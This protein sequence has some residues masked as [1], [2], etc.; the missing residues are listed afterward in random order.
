MA[1]RTVVPRSSGR[2]KIIY[3]DYK[4]HLTTATPIKSLSKRLQNQSGRNNRGIITTRHR[5]GKNQRKY[6]EI[7]FKRN[8]FDIPGIVKTVEYDPNRSCFISL[9][10]YANGKK[11]YIISPKDIKV[12]DKIVNSPICEIKN[13]NCIA[14]GNV[15]D[16]A[17]VHNVEIV[18]GA[19]GKLARSAGSFVQVMGKDETGKYSIIKLSSSETRKIPVNSMCTIGIVSNEDHNIINLGKA[20][21]S[22]KLGWKPTVR[23]SAMNPCDHPHG[24]GEGRQGAGMDAPRTPWGKR[25]MGVKTRCPT[26]PSNSLIIRRRK[27]KT[28]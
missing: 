4:K 24:G 8:M 23:G 20:G 25:H 12:G 26:K 28:L 2:R 18:P 22:R 17:F 3:I 14:I 16:G 13:G 7:D 9:V 5:G 27:G 1:I 6:R 19:G 21:K 15:P 10:D 11:A